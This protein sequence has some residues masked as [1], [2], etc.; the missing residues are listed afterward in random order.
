MR[1]QGESILANHLMDDVRLVRFEAGRVE[2][3]VSHSAPPNLAPRFGAAL[4]K[5]CGSRWVITISQQEGEPP[6]RQQVKAVEAAKRDAVMQ[7][8]LV[9]AIIET[10]P[11]AKLVAR[12]DRKPPEPEFIPDTVDDSAE[13]G[14]DER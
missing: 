7:H 1:D 3:N 4:E 11:D 14:A 13:E 12:R 8:P 6:L 5:A 9:Q 2:L 10:F